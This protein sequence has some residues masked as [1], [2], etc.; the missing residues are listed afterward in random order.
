M[1]YRLLEVSDTATTE[2]IKRNYKQKCLNLHPDKRQEGD[3]DDEQFNKVQEA[4]HTLRD[5]Q[6]RAA[7]DARVR[8]LKY[9]N[10][11]A[12]VDEVDLDEMQENDDQWSYPCRCGDFYR[13][14]G[15]DLEEGLSV[16]QCGGCSL[17]IRV[18]YEEVDEL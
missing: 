1:Y 12:V 9:H 3:K 2:E 4:W 10:E 16:V 8:E 13:I 7:Y 18:V 6:L 5:E 17:C 15:D 11:A 14:T